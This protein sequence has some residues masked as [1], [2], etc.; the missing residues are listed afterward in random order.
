M[1]KYQAG[2]AIALIVILLGVVICAIFFFAEPRTEELAKWEYRLIAPDDIRLEETL[3]ILGDMGWELAFTRRVLRSS[4]D[5]YRYEMIF[6]R[7]QQEE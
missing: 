7:Q 3:N 1:D 4:T 2:W 5:E 6:K